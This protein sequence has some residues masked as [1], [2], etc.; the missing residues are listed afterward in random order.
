V[1]DSVRVP[2]RNPEFAPFVQRIKDARPEAVFMFVPAGEQ[3]IAFM[4][5]FEERGAS[6]RPASGDRHRRPHRR[7]RAERHG[8]PGPG[9]DH[10]PPL[11]RRRTSRP[12]TPRS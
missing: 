6:P 3:S 10:Q 11:F 9:R 2:L 1:V 8:R 5:A 4:K 12:R 7:Q